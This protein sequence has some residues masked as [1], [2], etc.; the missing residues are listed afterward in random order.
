MVSTTAR[1]VAWIDLFISLCVYCPFLIYHLHQYLQQK[2]HIVYSMRYCQITTYQTVILIIKLMNHSAWS[3]A[4][5]YEVAD[6]CSTTEFIFWLIDT[7]LNEFLL[8][9][10]IWKFWLL[11][12]NIKLQAAILGS[13]WKS[14]IDSEHH[15]QR[16]SFY[17]RY[18]GTLGNYQ[19]TMWFFALMAIILTSAYEGPFAVEW[20]RFCRWEFYMDL[21]NLLPFVILVIIYCTIP[22]FDDN[23]FVRKEMTYIFTCLVVSYCSWYSFYIIEL[24][25]NA[26]WWDDED[27]ESS[28]AFHIVWGVSHQVFTTGIFAAM[29]VSTF[30]VNRRCQGIIRSHRYQMHKIQRRSVYKD[31]ETFEVTP[32]ASKVEVQMAEIQRKRSRD[33]HLRAG[34]ED[35]HHEGTESPSPPS[36]SA[37][38]LTDLS[39]T[40]S[41]SLDTGS[42][43]ARSLQSILADDKLLDLFANHLTK[44]MCIECLLS[45]IEMQQFKNYLKK[46]LN[47]EHAIV[48]VDLSSNVPRSELVYGKQEPTL[49]AFKEIAYELH[50]K[51]VEEGSEFEIN[52]SSRMRRGLESK[53][54]DHAQWMKDNVTKDDLSL[55][56]DDAMEE[57]IKLLNQSKGRFQEKL[58]EMESESG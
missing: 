32:N 24:A 10:F 25:L 55:L 27:P 22:S 39:K 38:P 34:S 40:G 5:A 56:F 6:Y 36:G 7:Y 1:V 21:F 12:Y 4:Y 58:K 35:V 37:V 42:E 48:I 14:I 50:K 44:E 33:V 2:S 11:G 17:V 26:N 54:S 31:G 28:D 43:E 15:K 47:V 46:Q 45:V 23:F 9:S 41:K 13:E 29:M 19:W 49:D 53:I 3:L 30:W 20:I 51:Y 16:K 52:I 57:N 8:F 18:R